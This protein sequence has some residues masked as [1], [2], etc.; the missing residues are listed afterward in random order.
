MVQ[1]LMKIWSNFLI[2][3]FNANNLLYSVARLTDFNVNQILAQ[4]KYFIQ[5]LFKYHYKRFHSSFVF[6][7][8]V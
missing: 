7:V 1:P 6:I 8:S 2:S 3:H 4:I 5:I